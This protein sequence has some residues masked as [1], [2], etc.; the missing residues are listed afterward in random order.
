MKYAYKSK[1]INSRVLLTRSS[2]KGRLH[3]HYLLI[4]SKGEP[5]GCIT[6]SY[7]NDYHYNVNYDFP[8]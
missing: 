2:F 6:I 7:D 1:Q 4:K 3:L 8:F 5:F